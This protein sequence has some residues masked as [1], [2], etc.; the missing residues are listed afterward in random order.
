MPSKIHVSSDK[1]CRVTIGAEQRIDAEK[2]RVTIGAK[3]DRNPICA[4][5][6]QLVSVE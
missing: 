5:N 6:Q 3:R 4:E 1:W 2:D